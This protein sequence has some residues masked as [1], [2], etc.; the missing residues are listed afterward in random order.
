MSGLHHTGRLGESEVGGA[1]TP[2]AQSPSASGDIVFALRQPWAVRDLLKVRPDLAAI[3]RGILRQWWTPEYVEHLIDGWRKAGLDVP[4]AV[5]PGQE[6]ALP[7]GPEPVRRPHDRQRP[8]A[9][10]RWRSRDCRSRT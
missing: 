7:T 10:R 3:A 2:G 5:G 6:G 1:L 4:T 8:H 9:M